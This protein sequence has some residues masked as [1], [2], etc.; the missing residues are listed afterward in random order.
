[1]PEYRPVPRERADEFG[2]ILRYSFAPNRGPPEA[3][4]DLEADE[5]R[6][7]LGEPRGIFGADDTLHT[8]A[9][10]FYWPV[11]LRGR[12][13]RAAGLSMVAT[14]PEYRHRGFVGDLL[15]ASL[16]EYREE[17][18]GISLLYPFAYPF[19]GKY[20][21]R[22]GEE[23][24]QVTF[25]P[26]TLEDAVPEPAGTFRR[27]TVPDVVDG[28]DEAAGGVLDPTARTV[29]VDTLDAVYAQSTAGYAL[30][31]DRPADW[32]RHNVLHSWREDPFLAGWF[33]DDGELR[34]YAVYRVTEP[35]E[36]DGRRLVVQDAGATD[37]AARGQLLRFYYAHASQVTD[38]RVRDAIDRPWL[39]LGAAPRAF[40][41]TIRPGIM[42]RLVDVAHTLE[43]IDYGAGA[44]ADLVLE[45]ADDH[46]P[47]N[48][49][50]FHLDVA[51]GDGRVTADAAADADVEV[52]VGTLSQLV[53]G[54]RP[55]DVL[56]D[57]GDLE[58]R[59][60]SA[61]QALADCFPSQLAFLPDGF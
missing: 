56:A 58:I 42:V 22:V 8:T 59:S 47:W 18:V 30:A 17:D 60:E 34:A 51:H 57:V 37:T 53:V 15:E 29:S 26:D 31:I 23:S 40:E 9:R 61:R 44:E 50:R 28:D 33:D 20:G 41:V 48:D 21:W 46:A 4:D 36:I 16:E 45:V 19:Y 12:F 43:A 6:W 3:P 52:D 35:D 11:R 24:H 7:S 32:W 13:H 55:V 38:V 27:V 2:A 39:D 10:H 1:M 14:P 5:G 25:E 54:Y 49:G